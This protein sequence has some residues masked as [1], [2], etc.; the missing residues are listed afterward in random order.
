MTLF[1]RRNQLNKR[2]CLRLTKAKQRPVH[3]CPSSLSLLLLKYLH[4][5]IWNYEHSI[6]SPFHHRTRTMSTCLPHRFLG[7][8]DIWRYT[9]RIAW[10]PEFRVGLHIAICRGKRTYQLE[11]YWNYWCRCTRETMR[12]YYLSRE[13]R[14]GLTSKRV[15]WT[16]PVAPYRFK[17]VVDG[18]MRPRS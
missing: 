5:R 13:A 16:R 14:L 3:V 9:N 2:W 1:L 11:R 17:F 12:G 4:R 8:N 10:C 15:D 6:F 7:R 18:P